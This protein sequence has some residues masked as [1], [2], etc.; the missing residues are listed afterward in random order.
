MAYRLSCPSACRIFPDQTSN[1]CLL[2]WQVEFYHWA[3]RE[4]FIT[5]FISQYISLYMVTILYNG[6]SWIICLK[7]LL[8]NIISDYFFLIQYGCHFLISFSHH[9]VIS[10]NQNESD[11]I[12]LYIY[13][14]IA[15]SV[16]LSFSFF[17]FFW[18]FFFLVNERYVRFSHH[19]K[20]MIFY[21][22]MKLYL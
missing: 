22:C 6:N 20:H 5:N 3:T 17:F 4:A 12:L 8:L 21:G 11:C 18:A 16:E 14:T 15:F 1:P 19:V 9:L 13:I 7:T 10:N 2:Q